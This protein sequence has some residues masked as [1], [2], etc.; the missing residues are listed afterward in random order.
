MLPV[1]NWIV[2][3]DEET[4]HEEA[5][6]FLSDRGLPKDTPYSLAKVQTMSV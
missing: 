3:R 5:Q 6:K 2:A 4:A 1:E